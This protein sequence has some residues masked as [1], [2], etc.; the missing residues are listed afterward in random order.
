VERF[1]RDAPEG[2]FKRAAADAT[3]ANT[4]LQYS[5]TPIL[6]SPGIEDDDEDEDENDA[7]L[8]PLD[9]DRQQ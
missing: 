8:V 6:R 2:T 9:P 4:E 1:L 3:Q 7:P 5:S